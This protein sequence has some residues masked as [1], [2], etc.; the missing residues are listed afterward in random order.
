MPA[1]LTLSYHVFSLEKAAHLGYTLQKI[2]EL[3]AGITLH[4]CPTTGITYEDDI[5]AATTCLFI[6]LQFILKNHQ[7]PLNLLKI[8]LLN[9]EV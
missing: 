1:R 6:C 9:E 3:R 8:P 5:H 7:S 2:I 4:S